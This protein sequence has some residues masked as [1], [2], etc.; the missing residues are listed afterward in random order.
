MKRAKYIYV[1]TKGLLD[2]FAALKT[3]GCVSSGP[4]ILRLSTGIVLRKVKRRFLPGVQQAW[5]GRLGKIG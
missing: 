4:V 3:T 2:Q 1:V 5:R